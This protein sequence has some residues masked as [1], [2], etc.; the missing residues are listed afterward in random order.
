M[1]TWTAA[2]N[3]PVPGTV[4]Q[5]I[6]E[7]NGW[8][9]SAAQF[10]RNEDYYRGLV[11]KIGE[12]IGDAAFTDDAGQLHDTVL[13]AKVPELVAEMIAKRTRPMFGDSDGGTGA[14]QVCVPNPLT[15]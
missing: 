9:D 11:V 4:E 1:S 15:N 7:R 5:A 13:C 10:S 8:A 14:G 3:L 6:A 2:G 12:M